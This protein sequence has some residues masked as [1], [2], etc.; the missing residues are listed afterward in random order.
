M[1]GY[2]A[3]EAEFYVDVEKGLRKSG[4]EKSEMC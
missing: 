4:E 1:N 2:P 3:M